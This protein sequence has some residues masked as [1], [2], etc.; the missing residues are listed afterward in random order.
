MPPATLFRYIALRS[1][2]A[3]GALMIVFA[4]LVAMIDLIENLQFAAEAPGGNLGLALTVT[5]LRT[6]A[7]TLMLTPFAFLFGSIWTFNQLNRRS[8]IAVMRSAGLSIWRLIGP[9]MLIAAVAGLGLI[10]IVDPLSSR[11]FGYAED[12]KLQKGGDESNLVKVHNDG[13][14]LRQRDE[15]SQIIINARNVDK[16]RGALTGVTVWRFA[17]GSVL[18]ERIDSE[19]AI[20]AGR[21]M[22]LHDAR[23]VSMAD[24][25]QQRTPI[26]AIPTAL[27]PR[28]LGERIVPPETMSLWQ[29]PR[30]VMLAEAAGLPTARYNI[31]FHDLCSTPLKLLAMVLLAAA[32][33]LRPMRMGGAMQLVALSVLA[34]FLLFALSEISTALGESGLAPVALAAWTPAVAATIAAMTALL[35]FEDG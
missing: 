4:S 8:E 18:L 11:L 27:T 19:E 16:D 34:G 30:F 1:I 17:P 6:P 31:R 14:W 24:L 20:L 23:L 13:L 22:E 29:L 32:F 2:V 21:T 7:I 3:V 12:I 26:Y 15:T 10:T 33:S 25:Q 9:A 35:H 5:L 28:D